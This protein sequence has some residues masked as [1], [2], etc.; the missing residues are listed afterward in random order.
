MKNTL[1]RV[2]MSARAR[3]TSRGGRL[4]WD[5]LVGG[6][7]V[8]GLAILAAFGRVPLIVPL[9]YLGM[10]AISF[11]AYAA[12]KAQAAAQGRRVPEQALHVMS[13]VG[14][15]PGALLAQQQFR[16]KTRKA[17]FQALFWGTVL[18]HVV[19]LA[20]YLSSEIRPAGATGRI[21]NM[22]CCFRPAGGPAFADGENR[23]RSNWY[24]RPT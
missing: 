3:R 15:W 7:W 9:W 11:A 16:H 12:D 22:E 14:G 21:E 13:L 24:R 19:L 20:W 5:L 10:S 23:P 18:A 1:T 2:A 6:G 17:R 8:A 4:R